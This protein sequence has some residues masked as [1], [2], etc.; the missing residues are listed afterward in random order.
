MSDVALV[1]MR[2]RD[3]G[4]SNPPLV[5]LNGRFY[6]YGEAGSHPGP[7]SF[8]ALA[9]LYRLFGSTSWALGVA[10]AIL[11]V[12]AAA[13]AIWIGH[14]RGGWRFAL[15][16]ALVV[17]LLARAYGVERLVNAWNPNLPMLWWFVFL[18]AVWSVLCHDL[19]LLPVAVFAGSYA[20]QTHFPYSGPV[21]VVGTLAA[22]YLGY[23]LHKKW[24]EPD[25]RRRLLRWTVLGTGLL[26]VLWLLPLLQQMANRPGNAAII[27]ENFRNPDQP[28]VPFGEAWKAWLGHLNVDEMLRG[29]VDPELLQTTGP[30]LAGLVLLAVWAATAVMAWRRREPSLIRLHLVVA[31]AFVAGLVSISRILGTLFPYLMLWAWGVTALMTLATMWTLLSLPASARSDDH[32]PS[33]EQVPQPRQLRG[34]VVGLA[35]GAVALSALF[36]FDAASAEMIHPDLGRALDRLAARTTDGL[37]EDPVGCGNDCRY[38]VS[39]VDPINMSGQAMGLIV[40]LERQGIPVRVQPSQETGVR[41]HRVMDPAKAD[42]IVHLA[43]TGPAIA[44]ARDRPGAIEL[45]Y[46]D[47]YTPAEHAEQEPRVAELADALDEQGY[48]ELASQVRADGAG[49]KRV[50]IE[51]D[52]SYDLM[53]EVTWFNNLTRPSA[54]FL[55]PPPS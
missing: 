4:F 9:P 26:G 55:F 2:V 48:E 14:R 53:Y 22:A 32:S 50:P 35:S 11:S 13:L 47:P 20:A 42:A 6:G 30:S 43:A 25:E 41:S 31:V 18:L 52:M 51:V 24:R 45:A 17:G 49:G 33:A 15:A 38:V 29:G 1:E 10:S 37:E 39:V 27:V 3:V 12:T 21:V 44:S 40:E 34:A 36:T 16:V 28:Q 46:D 19:V 54:V 7:L 8:Y 23:N 5:G